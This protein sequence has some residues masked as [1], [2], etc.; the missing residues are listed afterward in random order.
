MLVSI[1]IHK[2]H[3]VAHFTIL[4]YFII[5][6]QRLVGIIKPTSFLNGSQARCMLSSLSLRSSSCLET[7]I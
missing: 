2:M 5:Y 7:Q 1:R 4:R 6:K 3:I